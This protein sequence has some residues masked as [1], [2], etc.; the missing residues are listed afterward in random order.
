MATIGMFTF[1]RLWASA[2]TTGKK[3]GVSEVVPAGLEK[4]EP[5]PAVFSESN[6]TG[7]V[8]AASAPR[9]IRSGP[10]DPTALFASKLVVVAPEGGAGGWWPTGASQ[11]LRTR[12]A[13]PNQLKV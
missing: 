3:S 6:L 13:K 4:R 10:A 2:A 1:A 8:R 9:S 5:L 11:N 12:I 7:Y